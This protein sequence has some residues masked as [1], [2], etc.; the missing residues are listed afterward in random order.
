VKE[1]R[2]G[3]EKRVDGDGERRMKERRGKGE[4]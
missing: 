4:G 3:K 2:N 1:S